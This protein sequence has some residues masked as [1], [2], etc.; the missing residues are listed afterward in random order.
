MNS[1]NSNNI[2][3]LK[4]YSKYAIDILQ[5]VLA[6][7]KNSI[8][9][10]TSKEAAIRM[11]DHITKN[12]IDEICQDDEIAPDGEIIAKL[13]VN[14]SYYDQWLLTDRLKVLLLDSIGDALDKFIKF[15]KMYETK[16]EQI[17]EMTDDSFRKEKKSTKMVYGAL[18]QYQADATKLKYVK[19][20][21]N[22]LLILRDYL[23]HKSM[24]A[25]IEKHD[26]EDVQRV[27]GFPRNPLWIEQ[28]RFKTEEFSRIHK[29]YAAK[30]CKLNDEKYKKIEE[31]EN[32]FKLKRQSLEYELDKQI[33][34][35]QSKYD[36]IERQ[37]IEV[38]E[39]SYKNDKK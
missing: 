13:N 15:S 3:Y 2:L 23:Q 11:H 25:I 37:W 27:I 9:A 14:N 35:I 39:N 32:E 17:V 38:E 8:D 29:E 33:I 16:D 26:E 6:Y 12:L 1:K 22:D 34:T 21:F 36:E 20:K 10:S 7:I 18:Y 28:I 31:I 5:V 4:C 19:M 30:I 24:K